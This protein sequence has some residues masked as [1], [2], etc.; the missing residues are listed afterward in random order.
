MEEEEQL[1]PEQEQVEEDKEETQQ[2]EEEVAEPPKKRGRPAGW[3]PKK[4]T[5]E[6]RQ[7]TKDVEPVTVNGLCPNCLTKE[8]K[9][10][11]KMTMLGP[12]SLSCPKCNCWIPRAKET[13]EDRVARLKAEIA[14]L[15]T[16]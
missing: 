15:E 1:T 10:E 9:V 13:K 7:S 11:V 2:Q 12:D 16:Q 8:P 4:A 6:Q 5:T 3:S 14:A